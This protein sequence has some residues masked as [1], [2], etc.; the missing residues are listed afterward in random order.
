MDNP[1][2]KL[3]LLDWLMHLEDDVKIRQILSIKNES[4]DDIVAYTTTGKSLTKS[5][6][7]SEIEKGF[8][9]IKAGRLKTS[10]QLKDKYRI[11]E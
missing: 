3:E 4:I 8:D 2:L 9:D 11:N 1:A 5:Q 10:Q 7:I 6:Y